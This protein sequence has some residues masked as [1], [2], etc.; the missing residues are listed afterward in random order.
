[1]GLPYQ[2][3]DIN[4][5]QEILSKEGKEEESVI[6][7]RLQK[8]KQ[9]TVPQIY[10]GDEAVGG[11]DALL[12]EIENGLFYERLSRHN[13]SQ[14]TRNSSNNIE[15]KGLEATESSLKFS[16]VEGEALNTLKALDLSAYLQQKILF[17]TD[18]FVSSDGLKVK[19]ADMRS[20]AAFVEYIMLTSSLRSVSLSELAALEEPLRKSFFINLYNALILHATAVLG[21][22]A[23]S[24]EA[25]SLFFSGRS[26]AMYNIGG[27]DFSPDDIEHGI[28][29]ANCPHPSKPTTSFLPEDDVRASLALTSLDPR[30]HFILN[31]GAASCPPIKVLSGDPDEALTLAA[32]AYLSAE[33]Y[34]DKKDFKLHLPRLALWY[35]ADFGCSLT[36]RVQILLRLC[37]QDVR[38]TVEED[39][40][41][42]LPNYKDVIDDSFVVYNPYVWT[43]NESL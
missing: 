18:S 4:N 14:T 28:L 5:A 39:L 30:I 8:A 32:A 10:V 12:K 34:V 7:S 24:S 3:I 1:M 21:P 42:V 29:R 20:S 17:L 16:R 36:E 2:N 37:P 33:V 31:C 15:K 25:R 43:S 6:F 40:R 13:I 23:D 41:T 38:S 19:Y 22:P 26:G 35:G 11:C 9:S 27:H